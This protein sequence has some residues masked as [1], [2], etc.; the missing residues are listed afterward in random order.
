MDLSKGKFYT[1]VAS[2][3]EASKFFYY[4]HFIE[5]AIFNNSKK[6]SFHFGVGKRLI[7]VCT[8]KC[9]QHFVLQNNRALG[10]GN[11]T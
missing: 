4:V 11:F 7:I 6:V 1:L 2:L 9:V 5:Y 8:R 3:R 10:S